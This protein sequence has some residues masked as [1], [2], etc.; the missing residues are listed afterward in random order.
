[1]HKKP[2]IRSRKIK[3]VLLTPRRVKDRSLARKLRKHTKGVPGNRGSF[4]NKSFLSI[5]RA[6]RNERVNDTTVRWI[7]AILPNRP[8]EMKQ[9]GK[10]LR[11]AFSTGCPHGG[12]VRPPMWTGHLSCGT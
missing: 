5:E 6:A 10:K 9:A 12:T 1:M 7:T 3:R 4:Y 2:R 11:T 8:V